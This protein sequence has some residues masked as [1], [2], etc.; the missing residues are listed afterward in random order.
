MKRL[1]LIPLSLFALTSCIPSYVATGVV[2]TE[3][4]AIEGAYDGLV[5]EDGFDVIIDDSVA[6]GKVVVTTHKDI[7]EQ[8]DFYVEDNNLV[9]SLKGSRDCVTKTLEARLSAKGMDNFVASGGSDIS[10]AVV[11]TD[12]D[13]A[14]VA[15][16]GSD[17]DIEGRCKALAI[18]VSGGSEVDLADLDA[19][20][21][22]AAVSG[23]SELELSVS[24]AL[25]LTASGGSEVEYKGWPAILDVRTSG[26][27]EVRR[28]E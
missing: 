24:K 16:G 23:G 4:V 26:G 25:E 27:S 5:V 7:M 9:I 11:D 18:V 2:L 22:A 10:G 1:L 17:I 28:A 20:V 15:S 6:E 21:V 3:E 12:G 19:E 14:V 8:L 13:I